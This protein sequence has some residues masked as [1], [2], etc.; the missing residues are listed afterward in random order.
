MQ[1]TAHLSIK[2]R[3]ENMSIVGGSEFHRLLPVSMQ[4]P[5]AEFIF[6]VNTPLNGAITTEFDYI[7]TL[8]LLKATNNIQ[9][10]HDSNVNCSACLR[11]AN[12][13]SNIRKKHFYQLT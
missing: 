2:D 5:Q 12:K 4:L 10:L 3:T 8:N 6:F 1:F 9:S 11:I 7:L 13:D